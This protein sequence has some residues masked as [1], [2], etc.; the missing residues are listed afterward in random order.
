[1]PSPIRSTLVLLSLATVACGTQAAPLTGPRVVVTPQG[2]EQTV[3]LSPAEPKTG[4]TLD[5]RSIVVNGT[6]APVDVVSR[7]CGIDLETTLNLT[8]TSNVACGGYSVQ[9]PLAPGDSLL[10]FAGGVVAS[11]PGQYTLRV[12][13]LLDPDVWVDVPVTVRM[14]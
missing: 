4:D 14:P 12:R 7:I 10:G 3:R 8:S 9:G 2:L 13:H 11:G 6:A 1:M 5:I